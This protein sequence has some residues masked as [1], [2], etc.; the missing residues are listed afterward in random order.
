MKKILVLFLNIL[1]LTNNLLVIDSKGNNS[2]PVIWQD[3]LVEKVEKNNSI[4]Y[5]TSFRIY[6]LSNK[7]IKSISI[8]FHNYNEAIHNLPSNFEANSIHTATI[9]GKIK[10][11]TTAYVGDLYL[12]S[13]CRYIHV[14]KII[15]RY[16]KSSKKDTLSYKHN[17]SG[18]TNCIDFSHYM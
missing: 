13:E 9:A 11:S 6:N 5:N 14:D 16:A 2:D 10:P 7:T 12:T 8:Q 1:L 18:C 4:L 15:I 17:F 3:L